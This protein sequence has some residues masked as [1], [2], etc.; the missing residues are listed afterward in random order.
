MKPKRDTT[1]VRINTSTKRRGEHTF[2]QHC[3][4]WY[5][6]G[7]RRQKCFTTLADAEALKRALQTMKPGHVAVPMRLHAS[8]VR[9]VEERASSLG[10]TATELIEQLMSQRTEEDFERIAAQFKAERQVKEEAKGQGGVR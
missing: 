5:Q 7:K 8:L 9:R 2:K 4:R 1:R 3:V 10:V 6:E